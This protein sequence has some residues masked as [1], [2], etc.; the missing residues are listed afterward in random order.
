VLANWGNGISPYDF[1]LNGPYGPSSNQY[2]AY[3]Y[4]DRPIYR[5]GQAVDFKGILRAE[6][7]VK[8][9]LPDVTQVHVTI[10][11]PNGETVLDKDLPVSPLGTFFDSLNLADGAALGQYNISLRV[12]DQNY[13]NSAFTVAAYRAPEFQVNVTPN[14]AEI[15]RGQATSAMVDVTYF[16]GG[17]V[18]NR[19]VQWNVLAENYDFQPPWGGNYNW[20]DYDDPWICFS[21]WWYS[22]YAPPPEPIL[23][24]SGTTDQNGALTIALPGDLTQNGEPIS[25]SVRLTVEATV[26]GT[27]NQVISGRGS[28][29]RHSGEFYVGVQTRDYVGEE[30]KPSTVD[31]I[32]VDWAGT[33][34]P[35]KT[36]Q[37]D[38]VRREWENK[39]VEN[40]T[41]GGSWQ[42]EVK[43]TPIST[44]SVTTDD[45]GEASVTFTPPQAGTYKI[46]AK[47]RG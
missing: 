35:N 10:N 18:A 45:K 41:G 30:N 3:I 39:F 7:D 13:F 1:G 8:Y 38:V 4:T 19:P 26:T 46:I 22:R 11:S 34:L 12:N 25:Q 17:G 9:N 44:T 14:E 23:S 32:A 24:G 20:R 42:S 37:V 2:N 27:D 21:C 15:V 43:D 5:P 33:R 40:E 47:A 36:I 31:V 6:K 28:I 16:F 29:I